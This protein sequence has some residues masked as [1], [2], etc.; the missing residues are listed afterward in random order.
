MSGRGETVW[1]GKGGLDMDICPGHATVAD[2]AS[3]CVVYGGSTSAARS[4]QPLCQSERWRRRFVC[5]KHVD[6]R[7]LR[8]L[9]HAQVGCTSLLGWLGSRAEWL[10]CW[11]RAQ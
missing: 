10:A 7:Y 3:C 11:T 6:I 8:E 5:G 9:Q 2:S 4:G 1:K